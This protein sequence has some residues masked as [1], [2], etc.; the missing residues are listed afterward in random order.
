MRYVALAQAGAFEQPLDRDRCVGA[1]HE[2]HQQ[3]HPEARGE[4]PEAPACVRAQC[5]CGASFEIAAP[6]G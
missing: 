5:R 1:D 4:P 2:G 6:E 3:R